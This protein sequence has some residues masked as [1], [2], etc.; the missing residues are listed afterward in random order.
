LRQPVGRRN[1][2][3]IVTQH[4]EKNSPE[5]FSTADISD[6]ASTDSMDEVKLSASKKNAG[7]KLAEMREKMEESGVDGEPILLNLDDGLFQTDYV[8]L[9][10]LGV[11]DSFNIY[12]WVSSLYDH[13]PSLSG[14]V[15]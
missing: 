2:L 9:I 11:I 4:F 7:E 8:C 1:S 15:R 13:S 5:F 3:I 12:T 6:V 10:F 14:T